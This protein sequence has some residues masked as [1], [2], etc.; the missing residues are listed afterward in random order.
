MGP[1]LCHQPSLLLAMGAVSA[2]QYVSRRMAQRHTWHEYPNIGMPSEVCVCFVVRSG[3]APARLT[4]ALEREHSSYSDML[5]AE[6]ISW[7]E[8]RVRGPTLSLAWW[9]RYAARKLPH[10][11][12]VAK[13]DDDAYIHVPDLVVLLRQTH[14][15][16]GPSSNVYLG[17]LTYYNWYPR[18]FER[19]R[20]AWTL[21][22]ALGASA[23]CRLNDHLHLPA[24][25]RACGPDGCGRCVGPFAFASGFLIVLSRALLASTVASDA[26][27]SEEARLLSLDL[28]LLPDK[29][30]QR[31]ML[32]M[33]DVWLGSM[34]YR[35]PPPGPIHYVSLLGSRGRRLHVDTW[36]LR[37][38]RSAMLV[39]NPNKAASRI[40]AIHA[41]MERVH[42]SFPPRLQC[43]SIAPTSKERLLRAYE[44]RRSTQQHTWCTVQIADTAPG[45][46]DAAQ[47]PVRGCCRLDDSLKK[48]QSCSFIFG[49]NSWTHPYDLAAQRLE[50]HGRACFSP[51]GRRGAQALDRAT[52]S[53]RPNVRALVRPFPFA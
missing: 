35:F 3:S 34:L 40:L 42:C 17:V 20:H 6:S 4:E 13:I 16:A 46:S 45:A 15:A 28:A 21:G 2:P 52:C 25:V 43:A 51:F 18:I 12:F 32:I 10:A 8:S 9:L 24:H 27:T 38:S 53:K 48:N 44:A 41:A 11:H 49:S 14:V 37:L 26:L 31:Q 19:T 50:A 33:E 7:N 30:G 47:P 1:M 23:R 39:H 5:L 29:H 22:Q 36:D